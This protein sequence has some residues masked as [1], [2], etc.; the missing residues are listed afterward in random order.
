MYVEKNNKIWLEAHFNG[1]LPVILE[2]RYS[3]EFACMTYNFWHKALCHSAPSSIAVTE[4]LIQN[5]DLIPKSPKEFYCEACSLSKSL[6]HVPTSS[7]SQA[8]EKGEYIHSDLC[9]PF[10]VPTFGNSLYYISFIDD[11]TRYSTV[12]FL[13][14]KSDAAQATIDFIS[15]IETQYSCRTKSFRT[16]NGGEY[17]NQ[18][19]S[20]FF[21]QKGISHHLTPPYSPE[22]NGV[23]ERLNRTIGEGIRAMLQPF[24]EKRL[25]AEAVQTFIYTKNRQAHSSVNR[26]TPYEAFHGQKPSIIHLQPFGRDCVVHIPLDKRPSG[27]K[28]LSRADKGIFVGYTD[29]DHQYRIF[30]LDKRHI[31]VSADVKFSPYARENNVA[32]TTHTSQIM[33]NSSR[34]STPMVCLNSP[35]I[36]SN[37][38]HEQD[39]DSQI[40]S[41]T[42]PSESQDLLPESDI[43]P[44]PESDSSS[45]SLPPSN[46]ATNSHNFAIS[47]RPKRAIRARTFE[48]TITRE[49]WKTSRDLPL[50]DSH[51]SNT[52]NVQELAMVNIHDES[53]P[54]SYG[55]AKASPNWDHWNVAFEE[56]MSSLKE[57]DV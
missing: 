13:K 53:E 16:D 8:S 4:K 17:V 12:Q 24:K 2:S 48:D 27:S 34:V 26:Q 20:K 28:L 52:N 32:N 36:S 47:S 23:A 21:A 5:Q 44:E 42:V 49:C 57:N 3:N 56:E 38:G 41:P 6:H 15:F 30:I 9:G 18:S 51:N 29:V 37:L 39:R 35:I 7:S 55:S 46:A 11:L 33:N 31:V 50:P 54:R 14:N 40:P 45:L 19:L 22:S 10:P 1:P 25:W 43:E